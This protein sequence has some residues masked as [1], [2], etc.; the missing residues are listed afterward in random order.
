MG[1][2]NINISFRDYYYYY[3]IFWNR[4]IL[5]HPFEIIIIII[6]SYMKGT[7]LK[8]KTITQSPEPYIQSSSKDHSI[9]QEPN[10]IN[11]IQI[12]NF[13]FL[14]FWNEG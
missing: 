5:I 2:I 8:N 3:E 12:H 4:S 13:F 7:K 1:Q 6:I 11:H 10:Q 9:P 14:F